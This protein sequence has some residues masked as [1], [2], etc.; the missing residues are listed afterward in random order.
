M[1][2]ILPFPNYG[3]VPNLTA[4]H[5]SPQ[6]GKPAVG[7]LL[8]V[9]TAVKTELLFFLSPPLPVCEKLPVCVSCTRLVQRIC[10]VGR[11]SGAMATIGSSPL[12]MVRV[13]GDGLVGCPGS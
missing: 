11:M 2:T 3:K 1:L 4:H 12:G 6:V 9:T 8:C 10:K 7:C 13:Q 5:Q